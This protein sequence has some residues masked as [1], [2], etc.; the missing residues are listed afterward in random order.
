[1]SELVFNLLIPTDRHEVDNDNVF[2]SVSEIIDLLDDN[3]IDETAKVYNM[4]SKEWG[5]LANY[6]LLIEEIKIVRNIKKRT[7]KESGT[8]SPVVLCSQCGEA[9]WSYKSKCK[10]CGKSLESEVDSTQLITCMNCSHPISPRAETCPQC[11]ESVKQRCSVC[12]YKISSDSDTCANCGDPDP[13]VKLIFVLNDGSQL[14]PDCQATIHPGEAHCNE[15]DFNINLIDKSFS[16]YE[17]DEGGNA[18]LFDCPNCSN[19]LS[20]RAILCPVCK[21]STSLECMI[22]KAQLHCT[23]DTCPSCGDPD[24]FATS[25]N[26]SPM[27]NNSSNNSL[28]T[29]QKTPTSQIFFDRPKPGTPSKMTQETPTGQIFF[30]APKPAIKAKDYSYHSESVGRETFRNKRIIENPQNL[31]L[32]WLKIWT[33][34]SLPVGGCCGL[35]YSLSLLKVAGEG[36]TTIIWIGAALLLASGLQITTSVG[37]HRRLLWGWKLNWVTLALA[38]LLTPLNQSSRAIGNVDF[39]ANYSLGIVVVLLLFFTPNYFYWQKRRHLFVR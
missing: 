20:K 24:P 32:K 30:D 37:L 8:E 3:R 15:C 17:A 33:Y 4:H 35:I 12:Q 23:E 1:M 6:T 5:P 28:K 25:L 2:L 10:K 14:C 39:L 29:P 9:N 34:F 27:P 16:S 21:A 19:K 18:I 7:E 38:C 36:N 13:F 11:G 26:V 22:C 31:G